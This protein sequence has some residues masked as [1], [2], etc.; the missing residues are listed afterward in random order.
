MSGINLKG[1]PCIHLRCYECGEIAHSD[2]M[3]GMLKIAREH[4]KEKHAD[5]Y[6]TENTIVLPHN[7]D[8]KVMEKMYIQ[9]CYNWRER[10]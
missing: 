1:S 9:K 2:T 8:A 6:R 4:V 10:K 3:D 5:G 7:V